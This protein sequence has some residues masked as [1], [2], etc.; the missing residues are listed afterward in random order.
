MSREWLLELST[1]RLPRKELKELTRAWLCLEVGMGQNRGSQRIPVNRKRRVSGGPG[2]AMA[3]GKYSDSDVN[4]VMFLG[5]PCAW[6]SG[7][8]GG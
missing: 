4:D 3:S 7:L 5:E 6:R 8:L 2:V 1:Q